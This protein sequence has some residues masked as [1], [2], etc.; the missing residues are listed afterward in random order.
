MNLV[1]IIDH[2]VLH[3]TATL[4]DLQREC[5]LADKLGVASVCV[6]P[7]MVLQASELLADSAVAVGTV[8]GF[9][10]G[11][12]TTSVKVLEAQRAC[13][14]GAVEL[15]MVINIGKALE[16]EWDYIALDIESVLNVA[17]QNDALLKVIFETDYITDPTSITKL[18]EICTQLKVGFVKTS[19]GFGFTK[20]PSGDYNYAGAREADVQR[21]RDA[22]GP[23]IGVKASGGIRSA[24]DAG[25]MVELGATR[26]GTS[27]SQAIADGDQGTSY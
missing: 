23:Q 21:M 18:C 19:T 14:D 11:G 25:R 26:L 20:Q 27:A 22:C 15:D 7:Y 5:Q 16:G 3:P 6:K 1:S 8:I 9:P 12:N 13:D 2:A 10:H 4:D 24:D 17:N